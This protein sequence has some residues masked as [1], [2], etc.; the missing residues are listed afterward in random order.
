MAAADDFDEDLVHD[1]STLLLGHME[2]KHPVF[3][4]MMRRAINNPVKEDEMLQIILDYLV[5]THFLTEKP[6]TIEGVSIAICNA[7]ALVIVYE[8]DLSNA[9]ACLQW[10]KRNPATV[11]YSFQH[12]YEEDG[13]YHEYATQVLSLLN[14]R[15]KFAGKE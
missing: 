13:E 2:Q 4:A 11:N 9:E 5:K 8:D 12:M 10:V 7:T 3:V 14:P 6:T 15:A 1:L